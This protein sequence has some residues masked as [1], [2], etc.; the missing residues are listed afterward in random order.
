MKKVLL[1]L[2]VLVVVNLNAQVADIVKNGT[3]NEGLSGWNTTQ[4]DALFTFGLDE[5]SQITEA[6][7]GK[8]EVEFGLTESHESGGVNWKF[9]AAKDSKFNLTFKAKAS[10]DA[11]ILV[12]VGKSLDYENYAVKEEVNL[13]TE[14]QEFTITSDVAHDAGTEYQLS[15]FFGKVNDGTIIHIDDVELKQTYVNDD[16]NVVHNG[17]YELSTPENIMVNTWNCC[18]DGDEWRTA[19]VWSITEKA[20]VPDEVIEGDKS[21]K[22][23]NTDLGNKGDDA[24]CLTVNEDGSFGP[25]DGWRAQNSYFFSLAYGT[26]YNVSFQLKSDTI[27]DVEA[28]KFGFEFVSAHGDP[29]AAVDDPIRCHWIVN[30]TTLDVSPE[31]KTYEFTTTIPEKLKDDGTLSN[32]KLNI[33][34]G[35][36]PIGHYV[37]MDNLKVEQADAVTTDIESR[38]AILVNE[39]KANQQGEDLNIAIDNT[40]FVGSLAIYNIAGIK[41]YEN[42]VNGNT[43]TVQNLGVGSGM[44]IIKMRDAKN[45]KAYLGKVILK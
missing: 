23:E 8:I 20:T 15:F 19:S 5:S 10:E 33:W 2:M 3:F 31:V 39:L 38:K 21:L 13:T 35:V 7:S 29:N 37:I 11:T 22:F 36:L 12:Y 25:G 32:Y 45:A 41:I 42:N 26:T 14:T 24:I 9:V 17:D 4:V 27:Y 1:S 18:G 28:N 6:N 40:D 44:Y 34:S 16:L 30:R 43:H